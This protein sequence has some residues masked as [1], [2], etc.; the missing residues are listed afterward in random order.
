MTALERIFISTRFRRLGSASTFS[1][2]RWVFTVKVWRRWP[3]CWRMML[4]SWLICWGRFIFSTFRVVLPLSMRL[5]SR[6]S[7]MMPSSNW[8][9]F[10]SLSRCSA[11]FSG[12]CSS[13]FIRVVM[14]MMAFMGVRIS[15]LMLARKS[16]LA[17]LARSAD[18]NAS[19]AMSCA[20]RSSSFTCVRWMLYCSRRRF[21]SFS[22]CSSC[23]CFCR[24]RNQPTK[25]VMTENTIAMTMMM[26]M[27][28]VTSFCVFTATYFAGTRNVSV[29]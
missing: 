3:A 9:E 14:P 6:I 4:S 22:A 17:L 10:S 28:M 5:M 16:V 21:A 8:P 27:T 13:F 1:C 25:T 19:A 29:H 15:W 26:T 20:C 18:C 11:S 12:W 23:C 24:R 7:F 2:C